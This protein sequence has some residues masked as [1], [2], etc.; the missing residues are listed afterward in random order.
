MKSEES[1][2]APQIESIDSL[3]TSLFYGPALTSVHDS[4][5]NHSFD[6]TNLCQQSSLCFLIHCLC[7]SYLSFQG[8][9]VF[10][11]HSLVVIHTVKGFSIVNEAE[12]DIFLKFP[13]FFYDPMDIGNLISDSPALSKSSV[14]IWK[15]TVNV[16]WKPSLKHFEHYIASMWNYC[17]CMVVLTF[18]SIAFL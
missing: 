14:Y 5:K 7:L 3:A 12:I 16:L 10:Y 6:Y 13:C 17:H 2:S 18:F 1:S 9:M 8:A 15:F 11:F 4:C